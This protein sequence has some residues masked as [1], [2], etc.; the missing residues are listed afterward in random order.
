M[1]EKNP[2]L[3][4]IVGWF[5]SEF[6]DAS[7]DLLINSVA[8]EFINKFIIVDSLVS[9]ILDSIGVHYHIFLYGCLLVRNYFCLIQFFHQ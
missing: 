2:P 1:S 4:K 7:Y 8:S 9:G 3:D 5:P 6:L